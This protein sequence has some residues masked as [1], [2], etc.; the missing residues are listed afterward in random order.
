[1]GFGFWSHDIV[2]PPH[3]GEMYARWLQLGALSGI[4]RMHERGMSA[5]DC[6][7]WPDP[8][9]GPCAVVRP[10]KVG[11]GFHDATTGALRLRAALLPYLYTMA[12]AAHDEGL[13]LTRPMCDRFR[14]TC[15]PPKAWAWRVHPLM[16]TPCIRMGMARASSHVHRVHGHGACT[17]SCAHGACVCMHRYYDFPEEAGAYPASMDAALGMTPST[18]QYMLGEALLIAPVTAPADCASPRGSVPLEGPC[19]LT[20]MEVWLPP[21]TWFELHTGKALQG[22]TT[23]ARSVHV[24]DVPIYAKAGSVVPRLLVAPGASPIGAAGRACQSHRTRRPD[25]S[26]HSSARPP[27][28]ST[29]SC[30]CACAA[31]SRLRLGCL[32]AAFR[33]HCRCV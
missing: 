22:P 2:G 30:A 5:G 1:M 19:G 14:R 26:V 18:R 10:W 27:T 4:L 25:P 21:G 24:L 12:R 11:E 15:A 17:L 16:C 9:G 28:Q 20:H 7:D 29:A 32:S 13:T 3:D 23:L 6:A 8:I 33:L 31:A